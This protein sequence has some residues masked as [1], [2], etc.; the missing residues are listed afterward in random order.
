MDLKIQTE[1]GSQ[2]EISEIASHNI[3]SIKA[4]II[5][6]AAGLQHWRGCD[7]KWFYLKSLK[8]WRHFWENILK[9]FWERRV[10]TWSFNRINSHG[11][12]LSTPWLPGQCWG[13][14]RWHSTPTLDQTRSK[15]EYTYIVK[16]FLYLAS[17][18]Q[19]NT[20]Q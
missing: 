11:I 1:T 20:K 13:S 9:I 4:N 18:I 12:F 10:W 14:G 15:R 5:L 8:C 7:W 2:T 16:S 3:N 19:Y 17:F 6:Q